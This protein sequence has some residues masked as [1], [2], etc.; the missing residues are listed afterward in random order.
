MK[1]IIL[2]LPLSSFIGSWMSWTCTLSSCLFIPSTSRSSTLS[3]SS[4]SPRITTPGSSSISSTRMSSVISASFSSTSTSYPISRGSDW[5][6][7]LI[8]SL[9]GQLI[10]F[11][12]YVTLYTLER[13]SHERN[14]TFTFVVTIMN[15][16]Y[17][18]AS[19]QI[20]IIS[21]EANMNICTYFFNKLNI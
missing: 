3:T 17:T 16:K 1:C 21:Y 14:E 9:K 6:L 18:I 8:G 15:N 20:C 19:Q 5:A 2:E 7:D 10:I 12:F 11:S 4:T 13:V